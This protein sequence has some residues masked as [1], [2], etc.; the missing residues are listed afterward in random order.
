ML[1]IAVL[2]GAFLGVVG[3]V[4]LILF[5]QRVSGLHIRRLRVLQLAIGI[6]PGMIGA[7]VI[8]IFNVDLVDDTTLQSVGITGLIVAITLA[9]GIALLIQW[10]FRRLS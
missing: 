1:E 6:V 5:V 9:L 2:L 8:L 3:L 7:I 4:M 10:L